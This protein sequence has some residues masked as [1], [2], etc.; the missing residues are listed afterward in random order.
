MSKIEKL[1]SLVGQAQIC[2]CNKISRLQYRITYE[3]GT[4]LTFCVQDIF[5]ISIKMF[6]THLELWYICHNTFYINTDN[7]LD[8]SLNND[9]I[10]FPDDY[11][12]YYRG[13]Y[14]YSSLEI[15]EAY[16]FETESLY[17]LLDFLRKRY[18]NILKPVKI[19]LKYEE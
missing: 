15:G 9:L 18:H 7:A 11:Y 16:E 14:T 17:E 1:Y 12:V 19:G 8:C 13:R 10:I 3:D 2:T 6:Q 5:V 4:Q